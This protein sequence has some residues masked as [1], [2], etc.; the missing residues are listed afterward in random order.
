LRN[1]GDIETLWQALDEGVLDAVVSDHY[2]G[3]LPQPGKPPESMQTKEAGIAGLELSLPLL[4][5]EGV[6]AGRISLDRFVQVT[7]TW[8]AE[9]LNISDRKGRIALGMDADLVFLDVQTRW[10]VAPAAPSRISTTPYQ[11]L[12]LGNRLRRT[13]VRGATV[14]D[15]SEILAPRGY[16]R[17]QA[18]RRNA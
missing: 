5:H 12:E 9:L 2:L 4:Y 10:K 15:G 16:G 11:D 14:W 13:M 7:S 17:F 6:E 8:P 3:A 18:S 1:P